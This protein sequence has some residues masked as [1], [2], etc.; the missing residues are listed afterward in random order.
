MGETF[1]MKVSG[2]SSNPVWAIGDTSVATIGGDGTVTAVGSG[3]TTITCT[4]D[5][6]TL[7][8]IV[9]CQF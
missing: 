8:C 1:K 7:K 6:Q 3:S 2:T 4:V 5:G 9:R